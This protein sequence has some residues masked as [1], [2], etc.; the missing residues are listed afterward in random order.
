VLF[1][2]F[3][4]SIIIAKKLF[5]AYSPKHLFMKMKTTST[6]L[7][8]LLIVSSGVRAQEKPNVLKMNLFALAVKNL[9]FQYE[10]AFTKKS[11]VALGFGFMP[12]TNLPAS[13]TGTDP[14]LKLM[15]MQG[16]I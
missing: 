13:L 10:R 2:Y 4:I 12:S 11:S 5:T 9:S 16:I 15:T 6:I 8:M 3:K 14:T 1:I 7:L